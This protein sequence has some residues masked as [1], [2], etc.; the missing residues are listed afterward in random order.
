MTCRG[1]LTIRIRRL[2]ILAIAM[3]MLFSLASGENETKV[4]QKNALLNFSKS[5]NQEENKTHEAGMSNTALPL[6]SD[7]TASRAN[8]TIDVK[9]YASLDAGK[10]I[11]MPPSEADR[12]IIYWIKVENTGEILLKNVTVT[13]TLPIGLMYLESNYLNL[14]EILLLTQIG[15][16]KEG[17]IKKI[18]WHLGDLNTGQEKWIELKVIKIRDK[19][20]ESSNVLQA[21]GEAFNTPIKTA[22]LKLA[23]RQSAKIDVINRLIE[24]YSISNRR[25]A[26]YSIEIMNPTNFDL[27]NL[28]IL[29]ILPAKAIYINGTC[30]VGYENSVININPKANIDRQN[31]SVLWEVNKLAPNEMIKIEFS[32]LI[33]ETNPLNN[34]VKTLGFIKN[35]KVSS[36]TKARDYR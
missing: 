27:K 26:N 13:D 25:I 34:G 12:N 3:S 9:K 24:L 2:I 4:M 23:S 32:A 33:G 36:F 8:K 11:R 22:D 28:S 20:D 5:T 29:D 21:N 30:I 15:Y 6:T 17:T 19:V 31:G 1:T 18:T 14:S 35:M 16:N 10:I 7:L